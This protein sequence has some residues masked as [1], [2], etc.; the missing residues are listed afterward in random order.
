MA[1][2]RENCQGIYYAKGFCGK[3]YAASRRPKH[4]RMYNRTCKTEGCGQRAVTRDLCAQCYDHLR[5]P[6]RAQR[7]ALGL[8]VRFGCHLQA[9]DGLLCLNHGVTEKARQQEIHNQR[10]RT[11]SYR[12]IDTSVRLHLY[13]IN[14]ESPSYRGMPFFDGWNPKLGGL[15]RD[16][17]AWI[18]EN[19][20]ARPQ[21]RWEL[22]IIDRRIGF[23][24]GNLQWVPKE[25]HKSEEMIAKLLLQVR[26]LQEENRQL[27]E[28]QVIQN[29]E[30]VFCG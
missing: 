21:G 29:Q 26:S 19:I 23:M 16:G 18:F 24:P 10:M 12:I 6:R 4:V 28:A 7:I 22:H 14:R 1:C 8:C 25:A 13:H 20:G 15:I 2:Q 11:K 27:K 30:A 17:V 3:H 5:R 9:E